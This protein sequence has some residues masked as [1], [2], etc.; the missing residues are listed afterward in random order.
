MIPAF[1]TMAE[2]ADES[3]VLTPILHSYL[4]DAKFPDFNIFFPKRKG[5]RKPDSYFHPSTHPLMSEREL[6]YYMTEP[7]KWGTEPLEYMGTLSVTMGTAVHGFVQMCLWDAQVLVKPP[8]GRCIVC[9][10]PHSATPI[11]EKGKCN[12]HPLLHEATK[13]RGHMDGLLK[14][15]GW[16]IAGLEFKT[17]NMRKVEN[18]DGT[19]KHFREKW[20]QYYAQVQEYMRASGLRRV[21]VLFMGMGFPWTLREVIIEHDPVFCYATEV[22]YLS[23]LRHMEAGTPP[24]PC[25][26]PRSARSRDCL[27]T[28]CPVKIA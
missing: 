12:E 22:K 17:S 21:I 1:R 16:G 4:Y 8:D 11:Q 24:S 15:P 6:Y 20:P 3:K 19:L 2:M 27:A 26:A 13:T 18:W 5:P 10:R 9:Q 14:I 23:V 25:C 28:S 7:E